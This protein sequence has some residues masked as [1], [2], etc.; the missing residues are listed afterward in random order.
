MQPQT[1][2]D[3]YDHSQEAAY[4][5]RWDF[6]DVAETLQKIRKGRNASVLWFSKVDVGKQVVGIGIRLAPTWAV[7]EG[8][9]NGE[10]YSEGVG[11]IIPSGAILSVDW[12]GGLISRIIRQS[13]VN[14]FYI[15]I[16]IPWSE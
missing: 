3:Q 10:L 15:T 14:Q 2:D 11:I 13:E 12:Q 1:D 8:F 5:K 7:E 6:Y 4:G 9:Q 16:P